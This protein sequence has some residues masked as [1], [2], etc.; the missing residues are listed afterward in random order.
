MCHVRESLV[1]TGHSHLESLP[2]PMTWKWE[3]VS[4]GDGLLLPPP[5]QNVNPARTEKPAEEAL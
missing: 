5:S 2:S 4:P 1:Q 3:V